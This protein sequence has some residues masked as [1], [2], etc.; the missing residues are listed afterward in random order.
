MACSS[1]AVRFSR[2]KAPTA[3]PDLAAASDNR[4]VSFFVA[5]SISPIET[6]ASSPAQVSTC[7]LSTLIFSD[8]AMSACAP[9]ISRPDRTIA[10]PAAAAATVT[11][12]SAIPAFRAKLASR[13]LVSSIS[14]ERRPKPRAPAS[15]MPSNSART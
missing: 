11:A 8:A 7:R 15:P 12:A 9:M 2:C 13:V 3:D 5:C 10:T 1:E 4:V 14:V 6:P